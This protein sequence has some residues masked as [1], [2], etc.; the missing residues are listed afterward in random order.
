MKNPNFDCYY[1]GLNFSQSMNG[2]LRTIYFFFFLYKAAKGNH[3]QPII[4]GAQQ[5][6][7][8][9]DYIS[10]CL[11]SEHHSSEINLLGAIDLDRCHCSPVACRLL[12]YFDWARLEESFAKLQGRR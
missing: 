2:H 11:V 10:D 6:L 5:A 3:R 7:G 8:Y 9:I 12:I 4:Y 1:S